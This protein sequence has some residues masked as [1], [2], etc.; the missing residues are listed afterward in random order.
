M[1]S[2][3]F[4]KCR[5]KKHMKTKI[6]CVIACD[7]AAQDILV[8]D[9]SVRIISLIGPTHLKRIQDGVYDIT[10][11]VANH[12][13]GKDKIM[14]A[15]GKAIDPFWCR[16]EDSL[17]INSN[18]SGMGIELNSN[19]WFQ[20]KIHHHSNRFESLQHS[21]PWLKSWGESTSSTSAEGTLW[22]SWKACESVISLWPSFERENW[23]AF[24]LMK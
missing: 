9:W 21:A 15:A 14:L 19:Q 17:R 20:T 16:P 12:P 24:F 10:K 3:V 18:S 11:F 22:S 7:L 4:E 13:G 8:W 5:G 23:I 6:C 2:D 1:I